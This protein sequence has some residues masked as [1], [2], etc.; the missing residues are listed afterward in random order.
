MN[1]TKRNGR[2]GFNLELLN[3]SDNFLLFSKIIRISEI[4]THIPNAIGECNLNAKQIP[5]SKHDILVITVI[6][7]L[8]YYNLKN[9]L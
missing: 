9:N 1:E 5:I 7:L 6:I 8:S 2:I 3:Q 4:P